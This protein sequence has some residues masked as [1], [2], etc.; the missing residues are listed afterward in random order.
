MYTPKHFA[1]Q[2]T[3]A[4]HEVIEANPFGAIVTLN[5]EGVLEASHLPF[6]LVPD[7]GV[8]GTLYAHMARANLLWRSF[9]GRE[10]LCMFTG[11]HAFL[12]P[13]W[14]GRT[15]AV[16]TWNYVAVHCRGVP[17]V[18]E[19]E[20]VRIAQMAA[21]S[22]PYDTDDW[23]FADLPADFRQGM[24][25][26]IVTFR[27]PILHMTGKAKLS[28]NKTPEEVRQVAD[29]LRKSENSEEVALAN[30]MSQAADAG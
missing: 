27:L 14:Y 22:D 20:D 12:S 29:I 1:L 18:V 9:D 8:S 24:M 25:K 17:K 28:Q 26:G 19:D 21:L 30:A 7:E 5:Q 2:D 10:V 15:P 13:S 11:P 23:R 4:C 16:P 6:H 3:G